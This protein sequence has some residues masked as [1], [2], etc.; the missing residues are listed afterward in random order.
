MVQ[1]RDNKMVWGLPLAFQETDVNEL[2]QKVEELQEQQG[3]QSPQ[4]APWTITK[5]VMTTTKMKDG[6][7]GYELI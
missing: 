5:M 3:S 4:C 7:L 2:R 1:H 6:I